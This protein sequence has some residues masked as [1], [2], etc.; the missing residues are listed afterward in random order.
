VTTGGWI[1]MATAWAVAT[2]LVV[3]CYVRLLRDDLDR[4]R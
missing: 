1:F 2:G 3:C 4:P